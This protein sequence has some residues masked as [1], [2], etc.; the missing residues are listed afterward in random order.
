MPLIYKISP[1]AFKIGSIEVRWYAICILVGAIIAFLLSKK[2][3]T[4]NGYE[5]EIADNIVLVALPSG[6]IGARIWWCLSDAASPWKRG[7]FWGFIT[8]FN[9]GGLAIQ[10]GVLLACV[11]GIL[12][13]RIRYKQ[14]HPLFLLDAGM[15][16]VLIAQAIGRWGNFFN[17][18]VYGACV[19]Y[20]KLNFL[21]GFI[22]KQMQGDMNGNVNVGQYTQYSAYINCQT[23]QAA[24]PLYLVEGVLNTIGFILI[25][26]VL[27]KYWIKGRKQGDLTGLYFV[28]YGIVRLVLEPLRNAEFIMDGWGNIPVSVLTSI[29]FIIIGVLLIVGI[30]VVPL[31]I[32]KYKK[33]ND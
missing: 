21:P 2:V 23:T 26:L 22:Q 28:W 9:Q 29:G 20:S 12:F 24:I 25:S 19:D 1:I 11:V 5:G 7:D 6:I 10:G 18:E 33:A 14:I 8:E 16:N 31:I 32:N 4:K 13:L 3:F 30:R 17:Q 27:R 15:P